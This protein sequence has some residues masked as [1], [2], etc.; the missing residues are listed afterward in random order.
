MPTPRSCPCATVYEADFTAEATLLK[1]IAD[2]HR[3]TIVATLAR[4]AEPVCVCD[5]TQALPM[6]QSSVSHHLGI[7][8]DAGV[9]TSERR[10]TW[11]Y[12]SLAPGVKQ[13]LL[14]TLHAAIPSRQ[15]LT[16]VS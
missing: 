1:A 16:K 4:S 3:L 5:F 15:R 2:P 10:G 14:S 7:L 6:N 13:R 8:R 11:A 9:V 12:Y